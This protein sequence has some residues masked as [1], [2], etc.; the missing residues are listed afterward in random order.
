MAAF[1][2]PAAPRAE[3]RDAATLKRWDWVARPTWI[4]WIPS[5]DPGRDALLAEVAARVGTLGTL[6]VLPA[7]R[8]LHD[9]PPQSS[10]HNA[11]HRCRNV[12]GAFAVDSSSAPPGPVLLLDDAV[13]SG[14]TMT[15]V[16]ALLR[17]AGASAVLPFALV[18]R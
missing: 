13:D 8:R 6:P 4:S 1:Q 15:V 5:S 7:V 18:R 16:A 12:W 17:D 2:A 14:W 10:V 11:A 9:A 3:R